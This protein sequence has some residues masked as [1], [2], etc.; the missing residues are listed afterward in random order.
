MNQQEGKPRKIRL[1]GLSHISEKITRPVPAVTAE[2]VI[3]SS[4]NR[5]VFWPVLLAGLC[6][7]S[8]M[9]FM[10]ADQALAMAAVVPVP[11]TITATSIKSGNMT[12]IPGLSKSDNQTPV[13]VVQMDATITNQVISKSLAIPGLGTVTVKITTNKPVTV[14]GL[15]LDLTSLKAD[16]AQFTNLVLSTGGA[17]FE[18]SADTQ[19]LTNATIESP[20]LL[21]NSI[22]L[23]GLS[24]S[25]S[26]G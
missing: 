17:G 2:T 18:Q 20:Y 21:A 9:L 25:I 15:T 23:P 1:T 16:Q 22:T 12:L 7:M 3:V 5:R 10:L 8:I 11:M 26:L 14:K 6:A 19:T 24:L 13:G 4:T